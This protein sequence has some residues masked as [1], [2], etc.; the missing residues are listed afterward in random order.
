MR[1]LKS[2]RIS[3][4]P[5]WSCD[6]FKRRVHRAKIWGGNIAV[7]VLPVFLHEPD[8]CISLDDVAETSIED[9][10]DRTQRAIQYYSRLGS[11]GN[12]KPILQGRIQGVLEDLIAEG[13]I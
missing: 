13:L 12:V 6:E 5:G 10:T 9:S 11:S 3:I 4:L 1:F 2:V 8:D 7:T